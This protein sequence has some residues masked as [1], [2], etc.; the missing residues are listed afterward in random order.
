MQHPCKLLLLCYFMQHNSSVN[1]VNAILLIL[2]L[3]FHAGLG[4]WLHC[5]LHQ[6]QTPAASSYQQGFSETVKEAG[7]YSC[8]CANFF[9][10]AFTSTN[11]IVVELP[12][13]YFI[14]SSSYIFQ[15]QALTAVN[16]F[17]PSRAPPVFL[18]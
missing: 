8:S 13:V 2:L 7:D 4:L 9:L 15:S 18:F 1:T 16:Y 11:P 10:S 3:T 12:P 5:V 17:L 6:H 14:T